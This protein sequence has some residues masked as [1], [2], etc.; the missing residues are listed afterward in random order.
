MPTRRDVHDSDLRRVLKQDGV[1][2]SDRVDEFVN[3]VVTNVGELQNKLGPSWARRIIYNK[4]FGG[5]IISQL[6]GEGNRLHYHLDSD[7]CWVILKGA[8]KIFI[9]GEGERIVE[10]G[11][12]VV[13][14]Q[15]QRHQ[16]TCTG[17]VPGIRLAIAKPD[18][19]H[20]YVVD[21]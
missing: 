8:F 11:D 5:V 14:R 9:E 1:R 20:V 3:Q 16:I 15:A 2:D 4:R 17:N 7:E 21:E 13:V 10:K 12:I 19:D 6:P 18:V